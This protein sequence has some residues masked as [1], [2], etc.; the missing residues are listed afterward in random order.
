MPGTISF[1]GLATGINTTETVD[2]LIEVESR[3]KI[4]KEAEK[5]RLENQLAT[6]QDINTKLLDLRTQAQSLWGADTWATL[7]ATSSDENVLTASAGSGAQAGTYTLEVVQLARNHQLASQTYASSLSTVGTGTITVGAGSE[8][9][10]ITVDATNNTLSG[11]AE[12]INRADVGVT[13][14]VIQTNEDADTPYRLFLVADD[15]GTDNAVTVSTSGVTVSFATEVQAA[16]DAQVKLGSG[17]G[18]ITVTSASNEVTDLIPGVTVELAAADVGN[19]VTLTLSRDTAAV[20]ETISSFVDAFNDAMSLIGEQFEFDTETNTGGIL[21]GDR[22]LVRIQ[23]RIQSLLLDSVATGGSYTSLA[24]VGFELDDEGTLSF[25]AS[26]FQSAV[27]ADYDAVEALFRTSG[28]TDHSKVRFV[29]AGI[30]AAEPGT[31]GYQVT[32][33]R[34]AEQASVTAGA[35]V[36]SLTVD[37]TNDGLTVAVDGQTAVDVALEQK[38]YA[39]ADALAAEIQGKLNAALPTGTAV[40]VTASGSRLA[41]ASQKYGSA[42]TVELLSGD[43]LANLGFSA[44]DTDTGVDVAGTINGESA[45][46]SGKTLTGADGNA[47]TDGVVLTVDLTPDDLSAAGGSVTTDLYFAKGVGNRFDEYLMDLTTPLVGVIGG[48][49]TALENSI[50]TLSERI[51]EME[52]RLEERREALLER[53]YRME[54]AVNDLTSQG[55]F[56]VNA[57]SGLN[58]NWKWSG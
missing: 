54:T 20:E 11:L 57:L 46:G 16:Q 23:T 26:A 50:A 53:F 40:T 44:G 15:T 36:A 1:D 45:T 32:V 49:Q 51:A 2:Q 38:T 3:P 48:A 27:D 47:T 6:W 34:A 28:R 58:N 55:N 13:A 43:A 41:I 56:L 10:T 31:S 9:A 12:A 17:A 14:S 35:D 42:S 19:P 7:S 5:A 39:D 22:T 37:P 33:T 25:D 4:L 8:S 52:V 21:M 18:A 24:A 29:Y 30:D